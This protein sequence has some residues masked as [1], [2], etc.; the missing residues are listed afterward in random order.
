MGNCKVERAKLSP[1]FIPMGMK[2]YGGI[3]YIA[4][5][6]PDTK[7]CEVGSFPSP[8]RDITGTTKIGNQTGLTD[9][10][11]TTDDFKVAISRLSPSDE[12]TPEE[13]LSKLQKLN[14]ESVLMLNPGDKFIT[15]FEFTEVNNPN[16]DSDVVTESNF[17][18]YFNFD[19]EV[20]EFD[21][22]SKKVFQINFYKIDASNN[23]VK[24]PGNEISSIKF[25]ED[26]EEGEYAYYTQNNSGSIAVSVDMHELSYFSS[27]IR[28]TSK[29]R[30]TNKKIRIE[31]VGES[32]SDVNFSGVRVDLTRNINEETL[33]FHIENEGLGDKVIANVD[34]F[35]KD[36]EVTC[37]ITPYSQYGYFPNLKQSF[38][39]KIGAGVSGDNVINIFKWRVD[40]VTNRLELDFDFLYETDNTFKMYLEFYDLWSNVSTIRNIPSPSIYGPMRVVMNLSNEPKT[41]VF[42]TF[43]VTGSVLGKQRGGIPFNKLSESTHNINVPY[44]QDGAKNRTEEN[45]LLL[46]REDLRKNHFYIV[47]I[48]GY[49]EFVDD[50]G[51]SQR[52]FHDAYKCLYTNSAYNDIYDEQATLDSTSPYY[53]PDF[54][55]VPYPIEKIKYNASITTSD[56]SIVVDK[57]PVDIPSTI[58]TTELNGRKYIFGL[59]DAPTSVPVVSTQYVGIKDYTLNITRTDDLIYGQLKPNSLVIELP[60]D[61]VVFTKESGFITEG[62]NNPTVPNDTAVTLELPESLD[63]GSHTIKYNID[64]KRSV[65]GNVIE[66]LNRKGDWEMLSMYDFFYTNPNTDSKA[67]SILFSKLNHTYAIQESVRITHLLARYRT[68]SDDHFYK[69]FEHPN[70]TDTRLALF[71][72]DSNLLTVGTYKQDPEGG[73]NAHYFLNTLYGKTDPASMAARVDYELNSYNVNSGQN[74]ITTDDIVSKLGLDGIKQLLFVGLGYRTSNDD[75]LMTKPALL[76]L[77]KYTNVPVLFGYNNYLTIENSEGTG[78]SAQN[79]MGISPA[80]IAYA[81]RNLYVDRFLGTNDDA[82]YMDNVVLVGGQD[83]TKVTNL[84]LDLDVTW[85]S[86]AS[87]TNI[88]ITYNYVNDDD[89]ELGTDLINDFINS[90]KSRSPSE[91]LEEATSLKD[92][93]FLPKLTSDSNLPPDTLNLRFKNE[94]LDLK[95]DEDV[96][97]AFVNSKDKYLEYLE[98]LPDVTDEPQEIKFRGVPLFITADVEDFAKN[99]LYVPDINGG[100]GRLTINPSLSIL[101]NYAS[102]HKSKLNTVKSI[103]YTNARLGKATPY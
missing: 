4:S 45:P 102:C 76:L 73:S 43:D 27:A 103:S 11:F 49:E 6:N 25:R 87:D 53:K 39:L 24:I 47:R 68:N 97:N 78:I 57:L 62:Q 16:P 35:E 70:R 42:D 46:V 88:F 20:D 14:E 2:E 58:P 82:F 19:G 79:P 56:E 22:L 99:L 51:V 21:E 90:A 89:S 32:D 80:R 74:S 55:E 61:P 59:S 93:G 92:N 50:D 1:G 75:T 100:V 66:A 85:S 34:E 41:T 48:C 17:S 67:Q 9:G 54:T 91:T 44:L 23:I 36:D 5:Y 77:D 65:R 7:E 33:T 3:I 84:N 81:F 30:D 98:S 101:E 94:V 52:T 60:N 18:D 15:T 95:A 13:V 86:V 29:L 64:T 96:Y 12:F 10:H 83:V 8:E 28:E 38:N 63:I 37:D 69:S 26:I 40:E 71:P 72:V 31:A